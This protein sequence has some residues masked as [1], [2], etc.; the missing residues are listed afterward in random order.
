MCA[1]PHRRDVLRFAAA[2]ATLAVP[3]LIRAGANERVGIAVVG[4]GA[5]GGAH[6]KTLLEFQAK[7]KTQI[8]AVCDVYDKRLEAAKAMAKA[9]GFREHRKAL[10]Q[11]GVDAVL[12]ATPDHLHASM[13]LAA[14]DAGKHVYCEKPMT[15]WNDLPE[16]KKIVAAVAAK[17][18]A[19]QVGTNGLSD[20]IYEQAA[21]RLKAKAL[22]A[23]VRAQASDFRNGDIPCFSP[24]TNDPDAQPGKNL[25][26]DL[27]LGPAPK[28]PYEPGRFFAYRAFWD[29]SG[30]L[31]TD[32]FPH[33]L[34]PLVRMLDLGFPKRVAATGG[35]Y[36][37]KDGREIPDVFNLLLEYPN[38][39]SVHL[40]GGLASEG[41]FPMQIQGNEGTMTFG[42]P[43]F[44][45]D[46]PAGKGKGEEVKRERPGTLD[47]HWD[48]FLRAIHGGGKPRSD[49]QLNHRVMAAL[50]LGVRSYR[51]GKIFE[52]DPNTGD[53]RPVG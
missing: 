49:E 1:Q 35:Q 12:I 10:E 50:A 33:L 26:W 20:G 8:V 47:E 38:G 32:F 4:A 30:G 14:L 43:G 9:P 16:A 46:R 11:K 15:S 3:S 19:L 5:M 23:V 51:E 18:R 29:Y 44:V 28:R 31:A 37:W 40:A 39:P 27:F 21:A 22:G 25:D 6:L 34:A 13:T 45:V 7:G 2:A 48:D 36:V 24:K 42:G 41:S 52:F 17:K 53:G